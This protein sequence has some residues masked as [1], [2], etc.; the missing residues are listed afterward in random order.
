M[1]LLLAE[2]NQPKIRMV[3]LQRKIKREEMHLNL[4]L[5]GLGFLCTRGNGFSPGQSHICMEWNTKGQRNG[6]EKGITTEE[7]L[8]HQKRHQLCF[9]ERGWEKKNK[10]QENG[11]LPK[12]LRCLTMH[13]PRLCLSYGSGTILSFSA[14]SQSQILQRFL[15]HCYQN[16]L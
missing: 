10:Q 6:G 1:L 7:S 5:F 11:L 14:S 13:T 9:S 12:S 2:L 16:E 8:H 15:M 4:L 3:K